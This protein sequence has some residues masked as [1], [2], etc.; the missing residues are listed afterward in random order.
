LVQKKKNVRKFFIRNLTYSSQKL[1]ILICK[2]KI[3]LIFYRQI[4]IFG[5]DMSKSIFKT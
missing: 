3:V 1:K 5:P 2:T 4:L